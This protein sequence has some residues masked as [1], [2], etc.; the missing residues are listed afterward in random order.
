[1]LRHAP[2]GSPRRATVR[3][4][5]GAAAAA[6]TDTPAILGYRAPAPLGVGAPDPGPL[7]PPNGEIEWP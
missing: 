3:P 4:V 7:H 1:M 5:A 6:P 2:P